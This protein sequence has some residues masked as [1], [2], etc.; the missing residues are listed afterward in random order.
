MRS[1]VVPAKVLKASGLL[2][3]CLYQAMPGSMAG[4]LGNQGS[5]GPWHGPLRV[6]KVSAASDIQKLAGSVNRNGSSRIIVCWTTCLKL[7]PTERAFKFNL[8]HVQTRFTRCKD[9][10]PY[11]QWKRKIREKL[12]HLIWNSLLEELIPCQCFTL[13]NSSYSISSTTR[14]ESAIMDIELL[15][16]IIL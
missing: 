13:W 10:Q 9:G 15:V 8:Q 4:S 11:P 2:S 6:L 12:E 7:K 14:T 1:Q 5:D 3:G 16:I